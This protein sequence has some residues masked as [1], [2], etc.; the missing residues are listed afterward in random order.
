MVSLHCRKSNAYLIVEYTQS[1]SSR[2]RIYELTDSTSCFP[3]GESVLVTM[4]W[5]YYVREVRT[6]GAFYNSPQRRWGAAHDY[7]NEDLYLRLGVYQ[8]PGYQGTGNE[9]SDDGHD[10]QL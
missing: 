6:A 2:Y 9:K 8:V 10:Y 1:R 4:S 3:S 7:S 5:L